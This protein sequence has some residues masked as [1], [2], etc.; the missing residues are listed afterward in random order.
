[1]A[2]AIA[3]ITDR[4]Q[5]AGEP[6]G[7]G[8][9]PEALDRGRYGRSA[10]ILDRFGRQWRRRVRRQ[11]RLG[12]R[13]MIGEQPGGTG[14]TGWVPWSRPSRLAWWCWRRR[15]SA[16]WTTRRLPCGGSWPGPTSSP[17][18]TPAGCGGCWSVSSSAPAGRITS[19]FEGNEAARTADLLAELQR[20]ARVVV[21]TDAGH[22][23][24][25]RSRLP[26]GRRG[27]RARHPGDRGA[28]PV[29]GADGAGRVRV[30]GGPLLLRGF[31]AAQGR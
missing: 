27:G 9:H 20:G 7:H 24:G 31:P 15:R 30:A 17:P 13:A 25:V 5:P 3:V 28:G 12:H 8:R 19:Y 22:A 23:V 18:R 4:D 16:M 10:T 2:N 21:V 6:V 26:A 11:G 29:G 14:L 1:M